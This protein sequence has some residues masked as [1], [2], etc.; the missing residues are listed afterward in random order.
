MKN[1]NIKSIIQ[2][3]YH[4]FKS[5]KDKSKP[6]KTKQKEIKIG[7]HTYD[8]IMTKQELLL[9]DI[10]KLSP[11]EINN[12]IYIPEETEI[13]FSQYQINLA[14][15]YDFSDERLY[16]N[17]LVKI[18][19]ILSS[20]NKPYNIHIKIENR[21]LLKQ[22]GLLD[23]SNIN[24][25]IHNDCY[26]YNK[27]EYLKEE[28]QLARLIKPIKEA[29]LSPYEKF[30]AT[31]NLVK[32]FKEYKENKRKTAYS[33]YLRYILNNEYIVCVGFAHLLKT[34]LDKIGINSIQIT[35]DVDTSYDDGFS[36]EEIPTTPGGHERL[37][38]KIDDDKYNIHG[39]FIS[40]PTWD[41]DLE[42]DLYNNSA[43]TFDTKK[44]ARRLEK[45]TEYDL[46]LDFHNIKEYSEKINYYL[47]REIHKSQEKNHKTKIIKAYKAI[48]DKIMEILIQL[49]YSKYVE[50]INKYEETLENIMYK[51]ITDLN[52]IEDFFSSFLTDYAKY[53]IP[54]TNRKIK[55]NVLYSAAL[56]VKKT[57]DQYNKSEIKEW[58]RNTKK[59]NQMIRSYTFPYSYDY[60]DP[61]I[62]YLKTRGKIKIK[63]KIPNN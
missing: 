57:I 36:M 22:S 42:Y 11:E 63:S 1:N 40:D 49:D 34:L 15:S 4:L 24:L 33:R 56:T 44:E 55:D 61:R 28:E 14:K 19:K 10:D 27:E 3:I 21:E 62:N 43:I 7:C 60:K 51:R 16:L 38:V 47:K 46:L 41:N 45:L 35:T 32:Q 25:T 8:K 2:K 18:F 59:I 48:Y 9:S 13:T 37:I 29:D 26:E 30:L 52:Q 54:L 6:R 53:I 12:F 58:N 50:F 20:H 31:Y 5:K 39:I 23:C 17:T